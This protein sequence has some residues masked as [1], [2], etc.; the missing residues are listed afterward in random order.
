MEDR[1]FIC[2]CYRHEDDIAETGHCIC[3]L[4]VSEDYQPLEIESPPIRQEDSPWPHIEVY[5]AYWCSDSLRTRRFLNR[6]GVPYELHDIDKDPEAN[7]KV[8]EWG[9]GYL[10]TPVVDIDSRIIIEP[11]NEELSKILDIESDD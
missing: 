8:R 9:G 10:S 11:S 5:A 3:H 7:R 2:P 1:K 6:R 4:F